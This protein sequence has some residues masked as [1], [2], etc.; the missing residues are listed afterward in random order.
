MSREIPVGKGLADA[1]RRYITDTGEPTDT[2]KL[3]CSS[4]KTGGG[5]RV[6]LCG[7]TCLETVST[8]EL[9]IRFVQ[10]QRERGVDDR[11]IA[12]R[13]GLILTSI[14]YIPSAPPRKKRTIAATNV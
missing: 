13:L 6:A 11:V 4:I 8:P 10:I 9:R 3:L 12:E 1:L 2:L 7:G 14:R 5:L